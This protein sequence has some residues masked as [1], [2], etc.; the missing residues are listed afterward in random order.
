MQLLE[1]A[2]R[3]LSVAEILESLRRERASLNKTTIYREI[4]LL[5]DSGYVKKLALQDDKALYEMDTTHHHHLT[6]TKC[7][8]VRH[9]ELKENLRAEERRIAKQEQ[10]VIRE[11]TLEF[12]GICG[13]CVRVSV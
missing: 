11:H 7:G 13:R 3:P 1:S 5:A 2:R 8:D 10:F 12:F 6:C 9:I 4:T